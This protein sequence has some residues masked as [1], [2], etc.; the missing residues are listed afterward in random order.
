MVLVGFLILEITDFQ[1]LDFQVLEIQVVE[2]FRILEVL[3]VEV[4]EIE[5]LED[6][7]LLLVLNYSINLVILNFFPTLILFRRENPQ[8][9]GVEGL[10]FLTPKSSSVLSKKRRGGQEEPP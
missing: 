7:E 4:L 6:L 9:V 8:K 10:K 1:V 2:V 5:T 3:E